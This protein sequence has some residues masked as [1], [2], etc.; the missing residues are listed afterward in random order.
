MGLSLSAVSGALELTDKWTGV[1]QA[2]AN[3]TAVFEGKANASFAS[4]TKA[5]DAFGGTVLKAG[6]ALSVGLSLPIAAVGGFAIKLGI[7]A[8]EAKNLIEV[9]FGTMSKAAD[10]WAAN[11][12]KNF[13]LNRFE[14][15][16][17]AG[18]LFNMTTSMGIGRD[19]AFEMST[20]VVKLAADM[21]SF[22][23]IGMDEAL[24]KIKSGLTGETEPLKA[25]GILVDEATVK[26]YAYTHGIAAQGTE[27]SNQQ[28]VLARYGAILAQ[29]S[30]DQGDLARTLESPA[31]QLR[32]M[33]SRVEEA[34][35]SLGIALM[36]IVQ[37]V[38]G[39]VAKLVPYVQS[40]VEWFAQLP[41]PVKVGAVAFA[42][43][44]AAA[45]PVLVFVG[46]MAV[47]VGAILPL[48]KLMGVTAYG[49]G[50]AIGVM[51]QAVIAVGVAFA[52]WKVG[53]WI[54][55]ATGLTDWVER[56]TGRMLGLSDAEIE[57]GM[58]ARKYAEAHAAAAP[59]VKAL[60]DEAGRATAALA[61]EA[62]AQAASQAASKEFLAAMVELNSAGKGWQGTLNTINGSVVEAVKWY[63][64]AGVAQGA[65]ATAYGLTEA[66][67]KAVASAL[68]AEQTALKESQAIALAGFDK[69]ISGMQ[70][71][72]AAGAKNTG[73]AEQIARLHSLDAA[74]QALAR[75][76][77]AEIASEKDR[78]KLI[79]D[80]TARH[81][82]LIAQ[83]MA[84]ELERTQVVNAQVVA[85]L[86]AKARLAAAQGLNL[87]GVPL[88]VANNPS[89][90]LR[91][92]LEALD[93]LAQKGIPQEAQRQEAVNKFI[94]AMGGFV[95]SA[96]ASA[97]AV[98][99][100]GAASAVASGD[101]IRLAN[102]HVDP[103]SLVVGH[104]P[105][106]PFGNGP[107][108]GIGRTSGSPFGSGVN[109]NVNLNVSGV[110]DPATTRQMTD[111]V[112]EQLIRNS[113]RK[114]GAQ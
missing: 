81:L 86:E 1:L 69:R 84:K 3:E 70:A 44:L 38:V 110:W 54:G 75:S 67:V 41:E 113:G 23:N 90:V 5:V 4:V 29:T 114:F 49:T 93:V 13:G 107:S 31:N 60:G 94:V 71:L 105:D 12:S 80:N 25:I 24:T 61:A 17:T 95:A 103:L 111:A 91:K 10:D 35:T 106:V 78:M 68:A 50:F 112:S 30:N 100:L 6:T 89:E 63:L 66:Q 51:G 87:A 85:E 37:Q 7:E 76:V 28:K 27:L 36:P 97:A 26:T 42:A 102:G 109:M 11:L 64:Q 39:W 45:G 77:Y 108:I 52:A 98:A 46:S 88:E 96:S 72:E 65:L 92:D 59:P 83:I 8:V 19:A 79:E 47:S 33:R 104:G 34:A 15:E 62:A 57:A 48:L 18:V 43:L 22:R 14:T 74:E 101:V 73:L 16:K 21:A 58:A 32:I 9:S 82:E 56:T 20:G 2:A 40:A 55:E 99:G 53:T